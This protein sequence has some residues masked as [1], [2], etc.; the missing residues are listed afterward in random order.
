MKNFILPNYF[1]NY[2]KWPVPSNTSVLIQLLSVF[3]GGLSGFCTVW[4]M[5]H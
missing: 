2:S 4:S 5:L 3:D 1:M